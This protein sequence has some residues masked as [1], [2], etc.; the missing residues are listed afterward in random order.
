MY[1]TYR[2]GSSRIVFGFLRGRCGGLSCTAWLGITGD[3][4]HDPVKGNKHAENES[5]SGISGSSTMDSNP[6]TSENMSASP[7]SPKVSG[8]KFV[9]H[10]RAVST[11]NYQGR[12]SGE[13]DGAMRKATIGEAGRRTTRTQSGHIQ[14]TVQPRYRMRPAARSPLRHTPRKSCRIMS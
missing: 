12:G 2:L 14:R 7:S 5:S 3:A 13:R 6:R 4:N 10:L 1:N 8:L 9:L 11:G